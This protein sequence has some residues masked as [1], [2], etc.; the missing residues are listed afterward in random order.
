MGELV[1]SWKSAEPLDLLGTLSPLAHGRRD[2]TMRWDGASWWRATN[3]TDGPASQR[4]TFS[5][6]GRVTVRAWGAGAAVLLDMAPRLLG[7]GVEPD[8]LAS[9]GGK[10]GG[11]GRRFPGLRFPRTEAVTETMLPFILE[12]KVTSLEAKRGWYRLVSTLG[13]PAPGPAGTRGLKVPP[14]PRLLETEPYWRF[15]RFGIERKRADILRTVGR[16]ATQLNEAAG[17]DQEDARRRMEAAPGIG[18]WTSSLVAQV[19]LGD[20]DAVVTGDYNFPHIFSWTVFGEHVGTDARM[21]EWLEPFRPWR[22]LAQRLIL[23][24]GVAPARRAPKAQ[25]R[26]LR[27]I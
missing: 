17:M 2:P 26:D 15:H 16:L 19:A 24:G 7:E 25:L 9:M 10:V 20:R 11:F 27:A 5:V 6:D 1:R 12:Q 3:T 21:V 22:G 23:R 14:D 13:Q 8:G 4:I 18:P